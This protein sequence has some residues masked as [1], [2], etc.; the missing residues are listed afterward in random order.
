[1]NFFINGMIE[2]FIGTN[3]NG[4]VQEVRMTFVEV[5]MKQVIRKRYVQKFWKITKIV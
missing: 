3:G 4:V 2:G 1:V 5:L